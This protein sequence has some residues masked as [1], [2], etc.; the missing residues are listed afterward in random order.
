MKTGDSSSRST[1]HALSTTP[2][3]PPIRNDSAKL[4]RMSAEGSRGST[5]ERMRNDHHAAAR[6]SAS[7]SRARR[8]SDSNSRWVGTP[9]ATMCHPEP[10]APRGVAGWR[11]GQSAAKDPPRVSCPPFLAHEDGGFL[12]ATFSTA[13]ALSTTPAV[14][15]IRNDSAK[16]ARMA[17]KGVA[18]PHPPRRRPLPTSRTATARSRPRRHP[19]SHRGR[20]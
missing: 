8:R 13:H 14:P 16:F 11:E 18:P 6:R 15:P 7:S 19:R 2:A 4:A 5:S 17:R 12:I 10:A 20:C 1:A 9:T 3:V